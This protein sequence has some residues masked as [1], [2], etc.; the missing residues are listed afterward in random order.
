MP[1]QINWFGDFFFFL[2]P[3]SSFHS[4]QHLECSHHSISGREAINNS[5]CL[6]QVPLV[7]T[8]K[9]MAW[10]LYPPDARP[11][12]SLYLHNL[13][14]IGLYKS[15]EVN[16]TFPSADILQVMLADNVSATF[17]LPS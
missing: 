1:C 16:Y 8:C 10:W 14:Q 15:R 6:L 9:E 5:P 11:F 2:N 7:C 13:M 12:F 3:T 4:L 17:L